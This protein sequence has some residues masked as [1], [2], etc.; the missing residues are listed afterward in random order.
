[1]HEVPTTESLISLAQAMPNKPFNGCVGWSVYI[2]HVETTYDGKV[3]DFA[4]LSGQARE[5]KK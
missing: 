4:Q 5:S 1:M 3:S 2:V